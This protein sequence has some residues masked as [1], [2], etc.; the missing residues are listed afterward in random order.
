MYGAAKYIDE[1]LF[2]QIQEIYNTTPDYSE[3][4]LAKYLETVEESASLKIIELTSMAEK[5]HKELKDTTQKQ[6]Q[7]I[8]ELEQALEQA[9]AEIKKQTKAN[10]TKSEKLKQ[11]KNT[12]SK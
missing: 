12:T 11:E 6:L 4:N 2:I 10:E 1:Q 3:E 8:Q 5:Q 9:Q 7:T